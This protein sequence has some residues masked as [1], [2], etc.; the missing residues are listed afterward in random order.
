MKRSIPTDITLRKCLP[1]IYDKS[2]S[3]REVAVLGLIKVRVVLS[4]LS[5]QNF[6]K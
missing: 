2:I 3:R 4:G 1:T 5:A 6:E